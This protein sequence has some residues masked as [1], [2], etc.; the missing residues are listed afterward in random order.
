MKTRFTTKKVTKER[1]QFA[2]TKHLFVNQMTKEGKKTTT[3]DEAYATI[4][5][6]TRNAR[7]F[8]ARAGFEKDMERERMLSELAEKERKKELR[9]R[10]IKEYN[11]M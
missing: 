1:K 5:N 11:Q 2:A 6:D 10:K 4:K 3:Y 8:R 9:R 7:F